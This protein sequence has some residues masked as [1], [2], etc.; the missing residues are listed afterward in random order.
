MY[1]WTGFSEQLVFLI[2][3]CLFFINHKNKLLRHKWFRIAFEL[4]LKPKKLRKGTQL[5]FTW[6]NAT[7]ETLEKGVK[8][9][10]S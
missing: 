7:I 8:Y 5:T 3:I 6:S 2:L 1:W 4:D 9:V 10:Q